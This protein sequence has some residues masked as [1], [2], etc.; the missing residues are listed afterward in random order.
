MADVPATC[1][2]LFSLYMYE[3]LVCCLHCRMGSLSILR[4]P[5]VLRA[6]MSADVLVAAF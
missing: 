3:L 6:P 1:S 4:G 2:A 5:A